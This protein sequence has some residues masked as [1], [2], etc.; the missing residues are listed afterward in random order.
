[1]QPQAY[2]VV[3]DTNQ[4]IGAGTSWLGVGRPNPDNNACRRVL[5]CVAESHRGLYCG[6][7]IGEYIEK[8]VDR[9][10]PA[11]RALKMIT[12]IMGA[13]T[14]IEITTTAAPVPPADID[15]EVF[16][17]CA[18]D[19]QAHYLVSEDRSLLDLKGSYEQP[20]IGGSE[21]VANAL[22]L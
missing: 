1:M 12:Y 9:N 20:I 2:R 22:G 15:D 6:K 7:I 8:L 11:D 5:I 3:L 19:G 4:I 21:E 10:H 18:I 16:I 17:L 13:F 14:R